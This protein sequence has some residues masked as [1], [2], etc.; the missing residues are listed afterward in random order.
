MVTIDINVKYSNCSITRTCSQPPSI[1][2]KLRIMHHIGVCG[3]NLGLWEHLPQ[4]KKMSIFKQH[5]TTQK[6]SKEIIALVSIIA[7]GGRAQRTAVEHG[8]YRIEQFACRLKHTTL[9]PSM[10]MW[11]MAIDLHALMWAHSASLQV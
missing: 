3:I 2:I 8:V 10:C 1:E 7:S 4:Q 11:I 6:D 9:A 5:D